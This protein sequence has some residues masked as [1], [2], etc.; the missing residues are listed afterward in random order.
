MTAPDAD[1]SAEQR[2]RDAFERL[3]AGRPDRLPAGSAV[4]QNNVAKE[5]GVDP[6]ALRKAR[7]PSL[8]KDIQSYV[9]AQDRAPPSKRQQLLEQRNVR[10]EETAREQVLKAQRDD[11]H[12]RLMSCQRAVLELLEENRLLRERL[13]ELS[14]P[15]L[16]LS[17]D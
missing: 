12:S 1:L 15:V 13:A 11:A 3:K 6:T 10:V 7:F 9:A 2:Y 5:A 14:A 16:P 17:K 4:S 8:V